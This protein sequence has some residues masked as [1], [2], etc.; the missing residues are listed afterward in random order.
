MK[1]SI[2]VQLNES[3]FDLIRRYSQKLG[4]ESFNKILSAW[5]SSVTTSEQKYEYLEPW[6]QWVS[7]YS[8]KNA[9]DHGVFRLG[10]NNSHS[11]SQFFE[12]II[13]SGI[14]TGCVSPMNAG[15]LN[16][17][18]E[19]YISDPWSNSVQKGSSLEVKVSESISKLVNENSSGLSFTNLFWFGVGIILKGSFFSNFST[20]IYLFF[21]SLRL[22]WYRAIFLDFFLANFHLNLHSKYK[23]TFS[24]VF[25]NC[26]A[27]IQHHYCL[28]S[29]ILENKTYKNPN[30]FISPEHDPLEDVYVIYDKILSKYLNLEEHQIYIVTGL[31]QRPHN[32]PVFYWRL[33]NHHNFID[34]LDIAYTKIEPRM[35]RD[36]LITFNSENDLIN[37]KN[38]LSK[39]SD[40]DNK[41]MFDEIDTR[42]SEKSLFVT[43]TYDGDIKDKI[44]SVKGKKMDL[45]DELVFVSL[46]NGE[47]DQKGYVFTNK[48][49]ILNFDESSIWKIGDLIRDSIIR[50]SIE[51]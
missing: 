32:K 19:F 8:G 27:H 26:S 18:T 2:L 49:G 51:R 20:Y 47:H 25:L 28:N 3:N 48:K 42:L 4:L 10:D 43:L 30:W 9:N 7:F 33:K 40:E 34:S 11:E 39:I 44:F 35:T 24:S 37:A 15:N 41:K 21:K 31:S 14:K 17:N 1:K 16:E 12:K 29:K 23:T 13:Q 50:E 38:I 36:F 46:K 5:D 6:I 45:T 22:S